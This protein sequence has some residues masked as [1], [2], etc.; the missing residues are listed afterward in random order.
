MGVPDN[1]AA[2]KHSQTQNQTT[3]TTTHNKTNNKLA[4]VTPVSAD[5]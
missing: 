5:G 4:N 2:L 3:E 1:S